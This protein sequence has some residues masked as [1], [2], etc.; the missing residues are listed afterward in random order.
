MRG[1]QS[2]ADLREERS[3][4]DSPAS[5]YSEDQARCST[6]ASIDRILSSMHSLQA[7]LG[8]GGPDAPLPPPVMPETIPEEPDSPQPPVRQLPQL[9]SQMSLDEM[10]TEIE[11][12]YDSLRNQNAKN[13]GGGSGA[14]AGDGGVGDGDG[15][16]PG[17]S[18]VGASGNGV[19]TET[20]CTDPGGDCNTMT[21]GPPVPM[22][23]PQAPA[24]QISDVRQPRDPSVIAVQLERSPAS[25][26]ARSVPADV[27]RS[28]S[29][30][31]GPRS[32]RGVTLSPPVGRH[33][34]PR[35]SVSTKTS[36]PPAPLPPPPAAADL[37]SQYDVPRWPQPV[38]IRAVSIHV[39]GPSAPASSP[40]R[41][42]S[43]TGPQEVVYDTPRPVTGRQRLPLPAE[44]AL[45][46]RSA[47]PPT[48]PL[49]PP[50]PPLLLETF[51][52]LPAKPTVAVR[53]K[54]AVPVPKPPEL[55][56][57]PG[58]GLSSTGSGKLV[59]PLPP[60]PPVLPPLNPPGPVPPKP[61]LP[62]SPISDNQESFKADNLVPQKPDTSEVPVRDIHE[63][64]MTDMSVPEEQDIPLSPESDNN[65]PL[66]SDLPPKPTV[67]VPPKP[68]VPPP[69]T[70]MVT[71]LDE[72]APL[73]SPPLPLPPK[74]ASLAIPSQ[75]SPEPAHPA[76]RTSMESA[77]PLPPPETEMPALERTPSPPPVPQHR[78]PPD[79]VLLE[80][81]LLRPEPPP[82]SLSPKP[83]TVSV[84]S[85]LESAAAMISDS[86]KRPPLQRQ[87]HTMA[88]SPRRSPSP[89]HG[90]PPV[91][92][93]AGPPSSPRPAVPRRHESA[94]RLLLL[95]SL[96][97]PLP[98]PRP[99]SPAGL[100]SAARRRAVALLLDDPLHLPTAPSHDPASG[101]P[102]RRTP[103][104]TRS[105][106][107]AASYS[108]GAGAGGRRR[109]D[110][111]PGEGD[112]ERA[113]QEVRKGHSPDQHPSENCNGAA[114]MQPSYCNG[115]PPAP[116]SCNDSDTDLETAPAPP[117]RDNLSDSRGMTPTPDTTL[118]VASD[119]AS[120]GP[121]PT[122]SAILEALTRE[123]INSGVWPAAAP[124]VQPQK[125]PVPAATAVGS[126]AA[127]AEAAAAVGDGAP[128]I[129]V[130]ERAEKLQHQLAIKQPRTGGA[131]QRSPGG[132]AREEAGDKHGGPC[133]VG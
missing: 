62:V 61:C 15:G 57:P 24:A 38:P 55:P 116:Q 13:T 42:G 16:D 129:P 47:A 105:A 70:V 44:P 10:F 7:E 66:T 9:D 11:T 33:G 64:P 92:A 102:A 48:P 130:S 46:P 73:L 76:E 2:E 40:A 56:P 82:A 58:S 119:A 39:R 101:P 74:P 85:K 96:T 122:M 81:L 110:T 1:T 29:L 37:E 43:D 127:A 99:E 108:A 36:R 53:P 41:G 93:H 86:R 67:A 49:P 19:L 59:V 17:V 121:T 88:P 100:L 133:R 51:N 111:P 30:N 45:P 113:L 35:R 60:K 89:A 118:S 128:P 123:A 63:A 91:P 32:R 125:T 79:Q 117:P 34:A 107:A 106:T 6:I 28:R 12:L 132:S 26:R 25:F 75:S 71:D 115:G 72:V 126:E 98:P 21:D 4:P 22:L 68:A 131:V 23:I 50:P 27:Q 69:G 14:G 65:P 124:S 31:I 104:L 5:A 54:P 84:T 94:A 103:R 77:S 114:M 52:T 20:H 120:D 18:V 78:A 112:E 83:E 80:S 90:S 8:A 3:R 95:E 97:A 87:K 109:L